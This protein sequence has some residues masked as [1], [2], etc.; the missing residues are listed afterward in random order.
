MVISNLNE[1]ENSFRSL[2]ENLPGIVYRVLIEDNNRMIF[3]NDMVQT[4][5][6]YN[7]EDLKKGKV[8]SI[9]PLIL[10]ED[11]VNVIN[12]VKD[13]I[14]KNVPFEVEYRINNKSGELKWFYERGRPIRG[15]NG[16][17]SYIDGVIF[18]ITNRK[19]AEQKLRESEKKFKTF[20]DES[21]I[22]IELYDSSGKL[23][24]LNESCLEIFGVSSIDEVRGFEL[25]KD[26]NIPKEQLKKLKK[27]HI[28]RYET[29]F[30]FDLVKDLNLYETKKSGK[31]WIDSL[32][33][34]LYLEENNKISHYI[35]QLQE[36]TESK[37]AEQK[38]KIL[39]EKLDKKVNA[40]TNQLKESE[41]KFRKIVET[42]PDL[43]FLLDE[44]GTHLDFKGN[45]DLLYFKPEMFLG[46]TLHETLPRDVAEKYEIAITKTLKTK[47][48]TIIE[49]SLNVQ[50]I[51]RFYEARN[52]FFSSDRVA[53]FVRDITDRKVGEKRLKES[54][55]K[56]K[57]ITEQS[58]MGICIA[59]NDQIKYINKRYA[60]IFGY[61][62]EE[63][64]NWEMHDG[65][66]AIFPD[67]REFAIEQLT[68]KQKGD[69]D[70]VNHYQYRGI[71]KSGEI[72]WVDQYSKTVIFDEKPADF[73]T[74]IDITQR[75]N[76]EKKL[77][78]EQELFHALL[79]NHPDFIYFK[80][81]N[82][83]FQQISK[84]FCVFFG[85]N[86]ED[87]IGKTDL[88]LFPRESV[89]QT[90][91][92]DLHVIQTKM[93]LINKEERSGDIWVLTTKIP[94]LDKD[95]NIKGLFGISRDITDIKKAEQNLKESEE[96][97]R[98]LFESIADPIHVIDADLKIIYMNP[99]FERWLK[100][101]NL[102]LNIVGKTPVEAWPF[103]GETVYDEYQKVF[104][105]KQIHI[106]EDWARVN[107]TYTF[108]ET[109]KI[110]I[111]KSGNV[112]QV[113]TII[114]DFSDRKKAEKKLKSEKEK[115]QK[116]LDI[117]GV[118]I[119]TLNA[120]QTVQLINRKGCEILEVEESEII[121]M[122]WFDNYIPEDVREQ[123]KIDFNRIISGEIK[124]LEYY[125][126]AVISKNGKKRIIS[127]HN[128]TLKNNAGGII[129]TLSSG[130]DI[131]AHKQSEEKFKKQNVFL[132]NILESLTHPFYVINVKDYKITL[133]NSTAA[134]EGLEHEQ[135]CYSLTHHNNKP[136]EAPCECPL[137][138]VKKTKKA[139]VV[140]HTHYDKEGNEKT[141]EIYGY[142]IL[143]ESGNVVQMIEYALNV[144]PR[145]IVQHKL[146][147]SE[148]KYRTITEQSLMGIIIIQNGRVIYA[149]EAESSIMEYSIPEIMEWG[150]EDLLKHIHPDDIA[151][152]INRSRKKQ[153]GQEVPP[154]FSYR[155]V[156][157]SGIPKDVEVN[158]QD[159]E[160][161]EKPAI[162]TYVLD[163]TEK[164]VAEQKYESLINNLTDI[165]LEL[166]I[167][168][169]ASY[170]SPQCYDILGYQPSEII[171]KSALLFVHPEDTSVIAESMKKAFGT[172]ETISILP[173]RLLHKDGYVINAS[174]RGKYVNVG[175]NGKFIVAIRD[176]TFQK[177]I[178]QELKLSEEK[179]RHIVESIPIGM[180]MYQLDANNNLVFTGANP[181]A[182]KLLGV[183]NNQFIGKT[184]EEAFP[185]LTNTEIPEK[186][187]QAAKE[188]KTWSTLSITYEDELIQGAYEVT[189]FQISPKK[190]VASFIDI[191]DRKKT[192]QRLKKSEEK[193]RQL[194][195]NSPISLWEEDFSEVKNYIEILKNSGIKDFR[196]YFD[197]N[198]EEVKKCVSMI[199][200]VDINKK[201]LELYKANKK[202][203][204]LAGLNK[205]FTEV[206]LDAFKEQIITFARG[207]TWFESEAINWT[208]NGEKIH[209]FIVSEIV[210][211]FKEDWSKILVS[212][213]DISDRK[214]AE[215][216]LKES[217]EKF[218]TITEQSFMGIIIIQDG[219]F[220]YFNQQA[221]DINGYS[222]EEIQNW[223]P[224]EFAK[225]IH[226]EDSD[227]VMEQARNKQEG[228]IDV[229]NRHKYRIIKKSGEIAWVDNFS[230]TINYMGRFADLVMTEDITDK[231]VAEQQLKESEEKFRK[232]NVFL[233]NILES[234]THPF[235]VIN[236]KDYKVVLAN[237]TASSEGLE[238]GQ[239]CYSLTHH[240]SKP[241]EAPCVCPLNEVKKTKKA[242]VVEHTHYDKEGNEKIYE[243]YG[244]PILDE[245][246]NVVQ[247]IE[248]ALNITDRKIAQQ[249]LKKSE[250]KYRHL[251][252]NSPYYIIL[253]DKDGNFIDFNNSAVDIFGYYKEDL[254]SNNFREMSIIP[255][256]LLPLLENAI[257]LLIKGERVS[258]LEF[259]PI[260]KDG[261]KIWI[262]AQASLIKLDSEFFIY[263]IGQDITERKKAERKLKESEENSRALAHQ[264]RTTFDAMSESVFLLDL[265]RNI[266][267]CN[268]ITLDFLGKKDYD[269]IIGHSC[270]E[271]VH[272]TKEPAEWCPMVRMIESSYKE[273]SIVQKGDRWC[274]LLVD[275]VI[276]DEGTLVGAVHIITDITE[277][278]EAE[279]ELIKLSNL[280]S[281]LLSRTSHE[282]KTP[283]VSIKG[284][285]D[286]LLELHSEK[287]D[288]YVLKTLKQI[289]MGCNRL[290]SLVH[291]ILKTAEL[292]S[293][294][295]EL[296]KSKDDLS[297]LIKMCVSELEG[298]IELR[299]HTIN[300]E[301]PD[302]LIC[303]F[304]REQIYNVITNIISN[305][306]KYTPYNGKIEV[307]SEI[308]DDFVIV[309]VKDNGIGFSKEERS[310]IFKQFGKIERY[311][312]GYDV[313]S[314][315][316]G[317]GLYI[318]KKI[319]EMHGGE[320]WVESE[321]KDKGS[322]VYFSLPIV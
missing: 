3:F 267:Q 58:L 252:E 112:V 138:L 281:E 156:T 134:S 155:I 59:Q 202:E 189:A 144:T 184:I 289:K 140:E 161:N 250:E 7:P 291:D 9:D 19:K 264:W 169:I 254:L 162:L 318:S 294:A 214:K 16:N 301:I 209:I 279:Q 215:Q 47:L 163:V 71:K 292:K 6:G 211:G 238:K 28:I 174:A 87:I 272:G 108:T 185:Q 176:I 275:P 231:I 302:N 100:S 89:E 268:K 308:K 80:D 34:P 33:S 187:R 139:C 104:K 199:K 37:I 21:P 183:D 210:T 256:E 182:D 106:K 57:S 10:P 85:R 56:F 72:I 305:A 322:N 178:E 42:I 64:I 63:M 160:F 150:Q 197:K 38:L 98:L 220:K 283:L 269:E 223:K 110:P 248:Y 51:L 242:C 46:K 206:S 233:N 319:I 120:D 149:N 229:V 240:N 270:C 4:M 48:P 159:I 151:K 208:L 92:E 130:L 237:S 190:M 105:T 86:M 171:G 1:G 285:T 17:P 246:G 61:S 307:K 49:Y 304:E 41:E 15:D 313:I 172:E 65:L 228:K 234:L 217:E 25:F 180:H 222:L 236:I 290:E 204:F 141:Y 213:T 249:E 136:C 40:R 164:K 2:A 296:K 81:S 303:S 239:Y 168:G 22:G 131:T 77:Y 196:A 147:E 128:R 280:K 288:D 177:R 96:K 135:Y 116:Y 133:A 170:V 188:G 317:L 35:V 36:I 212:I 39:N 121:G 259:I 123:V 44:K 200:L 195:E 265:E 260:R 27:G 230:K 113:I 50:G 255:P 165:I 251:F 309:S 287:L 24:D 142:P 125:V 122:N 94:W 181:S 13:A 179:Y 32:I 274:E 118:I 235:Y 201:T 299:N 277:K 311:G 244:Y 321:G 23:V 137:N 241:C 70:V 175:G 148:E 278:K 132:N 29:I 273:S 54:E 119:V 173:Y 191:T 258:P 298:M 74:L 146:K 88:E 73:I 95:G 263:V 245:N 129:G 293:G 154:F 45:E 127:W 167:K 111:L 247:M 69:K 297:I 66:K 262:N 14:E 11:R 224:Y 62:V 193:Y 31:I 221:A 109:R 192:E 82:A 225:V 101:F 18:D 93:P 55:E 30:D 205:V 158:T 145:K 253:L 232:Q 286:I 314:E 295:L 198:P 243:I 310:L 316:S 83:R 124:P 53:L 226:P 103:I 157:K 300:L 306:I 194:F 152:A 219:L 117:A 126:N 26:P 166:D 284:F 90:H 153:Q 227:F 20:F 76:M 282:L 102:D 60:D 5:T 68:K 143:D 78:H 271:I 218:R 114:R 91:S 276:N 261:K 52:L 99:A 43:Y 312:Q 67:D 97:F 107:D 216:E 203:D 207:K 12:I 257:E 75:K 186:Y 320:I 266:L 79:D 115:A 315:G 8:S 84:R